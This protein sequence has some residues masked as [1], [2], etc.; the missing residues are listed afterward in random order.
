MNLNLHKELVFA[1]WNLPVNLYN[2]LLRPLRTL[3][4]FPFLKPNWGT[5]AGPLLTW[6]GLR[7]PAVA[8]LNPRLYYAAQ[9]TGLVYTL[10]FAAFALVASVL[11]LRRSAPADRESP[12]AA[13]VSQD[14]RPAARAVVLPPLLGP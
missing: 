1:I 10:P 5:T 2:Y 7:L 3:S 12:P 13:E 6:L 4:V 11:A 14:A 9:V 8:F